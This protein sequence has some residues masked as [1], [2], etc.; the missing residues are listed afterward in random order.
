MIPLDIFLESQHNISNR[1]DAWLTV[2][3]SSD[4][5][6]IL[7]VVLVY[8]SLESFIARYFGFAMI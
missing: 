7:D 4:P 1:L 6:R 8:R 2:I 3:A 5:E